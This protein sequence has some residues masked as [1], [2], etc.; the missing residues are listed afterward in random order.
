LPSFAC[1]LSGEHL[2]LLSLS[3]AKLNTFLLL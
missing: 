2:L 1:I 3:L